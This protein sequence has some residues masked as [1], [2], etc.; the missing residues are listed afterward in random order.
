MQALFYRDL[1]NLV[2]RKGVTPDNIWNCDEKGITMGRGGQREKAIVLYLQ[3]VLNPKCYDGARVLEASGRPMEKAIVRAGTKQAMAF[4]E[5]SQEF[6]SVLETISAAGQII[7][8]F[9][10]YQGKTHRASYYHRPYT[11]SVT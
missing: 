2:R 6:V 11:H 8:P 10:V 7:A 9:I 3:P 4:P 1:A 5:G